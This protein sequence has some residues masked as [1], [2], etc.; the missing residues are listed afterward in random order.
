MKE[1]GNIHLPTGSVATI[2]LRDQF[3]HHVFHLGKPTITLCLR[4]PFLEGEALA[5]FI[6]PKYRIVFTPVTLNQY[7][8]LQ[9]VGVQ[10]D[11]EPD[12]KPDIPWENGEV[13]R[14]LYLASIRQLMIAP[15][16][17]AYLMKQMEEKNFLP[18]FFK[19]IQSQ[20]RINEKLKKFGLVTGPLKDLV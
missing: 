4:T 8:W 3:I 20:P 1:V 13:M 14:M 17:G 7:K 12:C 19:L 6:Y 5:S 18:D 10:L 16:T 2:K 9:L 11:K 15:Q